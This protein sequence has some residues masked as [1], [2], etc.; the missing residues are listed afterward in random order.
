MHFRNVGPLVRFHHSAPEFLVHA[1]LDDMGHNTKFLHDGSSGVSQIV[2]CPIFKGI[3]GYI[4]SAKAQ[5][6]R[7]F[8]KNPGSLIPALEPRHA[9]KLLRG[10]FGR[11]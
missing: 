10:C 9:V 5:N 4:E 2:G 6:Y 7:G 11:G 1:L 8:I 3:F